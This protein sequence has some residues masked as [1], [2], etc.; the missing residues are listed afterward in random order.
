MHPTFQPAN[1]RP[2]LWQPSGTV[3]CAG[4][5]DVRG[6]VGA[7]D[8]RGAEIPTAF[9]TSAPWMLLRS[10]EVSRAQLATDLQVAPAAPA[11]KRQGNQQICS[12]AVLWLAPVPGILL[13]TLYPSCK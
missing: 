11:R 1:E 9:E 5:E 7:E 10:H 6:C 13:H 4:A 3:R 2:G 8:A 12:R